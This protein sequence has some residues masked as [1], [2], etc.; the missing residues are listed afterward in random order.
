MWTERF[1]DSTDQVGALSR[2]SNDTAKAADVDSAEVVHEQE[3]DPDVAIKST[4]VTVRFK[5]RR[6]AHLNAC[7]NGGHTPA[8]S[9][10]PIML[11]IMLMLIA[12]YC[13]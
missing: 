10:L 11:Q 13:A 3:S 8:R 12:P 4:R 7:A 6:I 5:S 2:S 9:V 1:R